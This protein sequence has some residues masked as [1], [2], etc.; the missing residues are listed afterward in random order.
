[1]PSKQTN[2]EES[3]YCELHTIS[4]KY[5]CDKKFHKSIIRD[6]FA[7]WISDLSKVIFDI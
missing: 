1:M 6:N 2:T 7:L 4:N 3:G 5:F